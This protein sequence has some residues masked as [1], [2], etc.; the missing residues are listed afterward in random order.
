MLL[1]FFCILITVVYFKDRKWISKTVNCIRC[2]VGCKIVFA[3]NFPIFRI[4]LAKS[5][6]EEEEGE[7]EEHR[8]LQSVMRFSQT[9]E[10]WYGIFFSTAAVLPHFNS[11]NIFRRLDSELE[12]HQPF[13]QPPLL[14]TGPHLIFARM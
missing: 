9:Q 13:Y 10:Y 1:E 3:P 11:C 12:F 4:T 7:E 14:Y 2:S 6:E 8:Q 5:R